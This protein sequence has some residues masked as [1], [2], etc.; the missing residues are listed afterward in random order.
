MLPYGAQSTHATHG[1]FD[2]SRE[3]TFKWTITNLVEKLDQRKK[4]DRKHLDSDTFKI[5]HPPSGA[6]LNLK[7]RLSI[8]K[9]SAQGDHVMSA[10]LL[11]QP[12]QVS[13]GCDHDDDQGVTVWWNV[14]IQGEEGFDPGLS[15]LMASSLEKSYFGADKCEDDVVSASEG[16][17]SMVFGGSLGEAH[18]VRLNLEV[19][20]PKGTVGRAEPVETA[21]LS[22]SEF[23]QSG[24]H[25]DVK[26]V[27]QGQQFGCHKIILAQRSQV[28]KA[29]FASENYQE[30]KSGEVAINDIAP[31]ELDAFL[32]FVYSGECGENVKKH[33]KALL[34]VADKYDVPDLMSVVQKKLAAT[35]ASDNAVEFMLLANMCNAQLL[36]KKAIQVIASN[37]D[38]VSKQD[39]W[40][41]LKSENY[42]I[43]SLIEIFAH[44]LK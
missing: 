12:T 16:R 2:G 29:M 34:V 8:K 25:S 1:S 3:H 6:H 32:K 43:V 11:R 10:V 7:L 4:D 5:S 17:C 20:W 38:E 24:I 22:F 21:K 15:T 13:L 36:K 26:L 28:F 42:D 9:Y 30:A 35:L 23:L 41:E 19:L 39:R 33:A 40:L 37:L 31:E 18:L 14:Q 27:C 44:N